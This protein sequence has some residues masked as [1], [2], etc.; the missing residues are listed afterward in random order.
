[1]IEERSA[2][3]VIF[4]KSGKGIIFLLLNYPT[5]HWDFVKGKI[6]TAEST[7]ETA[8]RE[9]KEET[10]ITD[11]EFI[12]GLEEKIEYNFQYDGNLIH[13]QVIF[14]LAETKTSEVNVSFEHTDY[15]WLD[16]EKAL[17]KITYQNAKNVLSKAQNLLIKA[18]LL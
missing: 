13:K 16:Y 11:L 14:F 3:V 15:I 17:K 1:M 7:K 8:I 5:G 10:G 2:G 9:T 18:K 4:R 6:E 12:D